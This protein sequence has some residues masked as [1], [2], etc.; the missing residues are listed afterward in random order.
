[1]NYNKKIRELQKQIEEIKIKQH[2]SGMEGA[3]KSY[4]SE[5]EQN[6][7]KQNLNLWKYA[8]KKELS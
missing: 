7:Q 1:M 8:I 3:I 5:Q 4:V 6:L 2:N